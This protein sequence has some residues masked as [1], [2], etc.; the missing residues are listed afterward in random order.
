M[1]ASPRNKDNTWL[2]VRMMCPNGTEYQPVSWRF[3]EITIQNYKR[4]VLGQKKTLSSHQKIISFRQYPHTDKWP[5]ISSVYCFFP[6]R[7]KNTGLV[8][9]FFITLKMFV[10]IQ[11]SSLVT[12]SIDPNFWKTSAL[13]EI[14]LFY[15]RH[16]CS[17]SIEWY[18][19]CVH[20]CY[21]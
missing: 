20:L 19:N 6:V 1:H 11:T 17:I 14:N 4:V 10:I 12:V 8:S 3:T 5:D 2:G 13:T 7:F 9:S 15:R 21:F 18:S 16:L